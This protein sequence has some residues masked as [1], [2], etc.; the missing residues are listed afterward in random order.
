M[1]PQRSSNFQLS[2]YLANLRLIFLNLK[3]L[4]HYPKSGSSW[5]I[6]LPLPSNYWKDLPVSQPDGSSP[7]PH[8]NPC[9]WDSHWNVKGSYHSTHHQQFLC[10]VAAKIQ[11]QSPRLRFCFP[12]PLLI[13]TLDLL[14]TSHITKQSFRQRLTSRKLI[15]EVSSS[16]RNEGWRTGLTGPFYG[17]LKPNPSRHPL[18]H[19]MEY[20]SELFSWRAEKRGLYPTLFLICQGLSA[21]L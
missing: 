4:K 20:I 16:S 15:W 18:E 21:E 8:L 19:H 11:F 5:F 14:T 3:L 2:W 1:L 10:Y 9:Q 13:P 17:K 7:V 6:S 12:G